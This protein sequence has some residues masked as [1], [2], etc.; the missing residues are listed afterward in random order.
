MLAKIQ[1]LDRNDQSFRSVAEIQDKGYISIFDL[2]TTKIGVQLLVV[3]VRSWFDNHEFLSK[4]I[5][6]CHVNNSALID[7]N[8]LFGEEFG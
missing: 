4:K 1:D 6:Q 8:K 3:L 2:H 7:Q 5:L